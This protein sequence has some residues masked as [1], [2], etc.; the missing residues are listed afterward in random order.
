MWVFEEKELNEIPE[1]YIGFVYCITNLINGKQYIGKKNF[2]STRRIKQKN[3]INKKKIKSESN[4]KLYF[5]S[6]DVLISDVEANGPH[7][8]RREI[9]HFCK[10]KA[11]MS[12]FE[13]KEQIDRRVLF[14]PEKYYNNF[15]GCR[16]HRKHLKIL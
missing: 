6:N 15:I 2:Y 10:N 5:G 7:N 9:L 16:I 4:W 12:Y 8:F 1:Q 13:I 14:L 11:E 3:K